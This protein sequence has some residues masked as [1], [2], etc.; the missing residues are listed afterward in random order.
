MT[1]SEILLAQQLI[2]NLSTGDKKC[3]KEIYGESWDAINNKKNFGKKFHIA[4][5]NNKLSGIKFTE[6]RNTGR[7][8]E[9]EKL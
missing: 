6:I 4:V 9:Y 2:N 8:N 1:D 5:S 3:V 7:C